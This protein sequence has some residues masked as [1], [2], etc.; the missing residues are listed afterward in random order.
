MKQEIHRLRKNEIDR[1]N[2]LTHTFVIVIV[3]MHEKHVRNR[4]HVANRNRDRFRKGER[5]CEEDPVQIGH[6]NR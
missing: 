6:G 1:E 5:K 2:D 3:I 4:V